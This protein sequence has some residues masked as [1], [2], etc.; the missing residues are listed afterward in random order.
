M[1]TR[2]E[3][4]RDAAIVASLRALAEA[5]KE[6]ATSLKRIEEMLRRQENK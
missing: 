3:L 4:E 6:S 1:I 2:H 5:A